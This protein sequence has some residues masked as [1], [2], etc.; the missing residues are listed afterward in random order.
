MYDVSSLFIPAFISGLITFFAPCTFP[1]I[2]AYLG[3]ISGATADELSDHLKRKELRWKIVANGLL[4][5]LG[6]AAVFISLG[7]GF[8]LIGSSISGFRLWLTKI[9]G[10]LV[11]VAGLSMLG[12][13]KIRGFNLIRL[14]NINRF[15]PKT[16][17]FVLGI[18]LGAGWTPCVGPILGA[19][20]TLASASATIW[21]GAQLLTAF[22]L[23]L[24][25]PFIIVAFLFGSAQK[26]FSIINRYLPALSAVSGVV[27]MLFGYLIFT[28][29]LGILMGFGFKLLRFIPY[30]DFI[31]NFI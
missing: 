15:D 28:S 10:I 30:Q 31:Y 25:I 19:V 7:A 2:P 22:S 27:L 6:F 29:Q 17:A 4:F 1:L 16:R 18:A 21:T 14:K 20:L 9:A 5:I 8:G 11:F 23:G 13:I 3:L 12:A 24:A 26:Y